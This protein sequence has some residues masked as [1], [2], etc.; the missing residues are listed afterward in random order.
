MAEYQII[1]GRQGVDAPG[2]NAHQGQNL[3]TRLSV[4]GSE[5]ETNNG[6]SDASAAETDTGDGAFL[7]RNPGR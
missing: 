2:I 3:R 6:G 4:Q 1:S 5:K 7:G